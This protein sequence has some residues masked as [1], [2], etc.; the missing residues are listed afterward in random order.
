MF[1][2]PFKNVF[3]KYYKYVHTFKFGRIHYKLCEKLPFYHGLVIQVPPN[4]YYSLL[5]ILVEGKIS[6]T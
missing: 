4:T 2:F 6:K 5:K 3:A 1:Y